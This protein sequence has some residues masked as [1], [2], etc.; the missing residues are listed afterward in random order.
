MDKIINI[1]DIWIQN[2]NNFAQ[3]SIST[4]IKVYAARNQPNI[5]KGMNDN[6]IGKIGEE[7]VCAYAQNILPDITSP[8]YTIYKVRNKSWEKDLQS[9]KANI[10]I[11]VKTQTVES[12]NKYGESWVFQNQDKGIHGSGKT[13]ENNYIAFTLIDLDNKIGIIRAIV[14]VSWLHNNNLFMP[15]K[16]AHLQNNKKAVYYNELL[17]YENELWQL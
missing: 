6:K 16:L 17:K 15:M 3:Q 10:K 9:I 11:G 12:A 14:K 2:A 13:E 7:V 5:Q 8:D 1:K 4:N